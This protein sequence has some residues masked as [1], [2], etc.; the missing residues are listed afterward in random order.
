MSK[1]SDRKETTGQSMTGEQTPPVRRYPK[2]SP[3]DPIYKAGFVFG[4]VRRSTPPSSKPAASA[5]PPTETPSTTPSPLN[6]PKLPPEPRL[7]DFKDEETFLEA[8][9]AYRRTYG[10]AHRLQNALRSKGSQSS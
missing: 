4:I 7:E 8:R 2:V 6:L 5:P 1:S 3:D 9:D 10:S